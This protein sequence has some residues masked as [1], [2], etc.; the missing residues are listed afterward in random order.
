M[1]ILLQRGYLGS[2]DRRC[3]HTIE[4]TGHLR[5]HLKVTS[6]Y[7]L[8]LYYY[9]SSIVYHCRH[10][11][12]LLWYGPLAS[13]RANVVAQTDGRKESWRQEM[14]NGGGGGR[15]KNHLLT[16]ILQH[17]KV[18]HST[19]SLCSKQLCP[20]TRFCTQLMYCKHKFLHSTYI[21]WL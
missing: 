15:K 11:M 17:H 14:E 16:S 5:V 13:T 10:T 2:T 18:K 1:T 4:K 19:K 21:T 9:F 20:N 8:R 7:Y 6:L 12:I 3:K